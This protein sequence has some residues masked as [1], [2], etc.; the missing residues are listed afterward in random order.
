MPLN[1][2]GMQTGRKLLGVLWLLQID[3]LYGCDVVPFETVKSMVQMEGIRKY[4]LYGYPTPGYT[5][6]SFRFNFLTTCESLASDMNQTGGLYDYIWDNSKFSAH[7]GDCII[8]NITSNETT[9]TFTST[10]L[11]SKTTRS[12]TS[13][14]KT[15]LT[16]MTAGVDTTGSK[17]LTIGSTFSTKSQNIDASTNIV[18]TTLPKTVTYTTKQIDTSS[19][20]SSLLSTYSPSVTS[21][22]SGLLAASLES[23]KTHSNVPIIIALC[24][25]CSVMVIGVVLLCRRKKHGEIIFETHYEEPVCRNKPDDHGLRLVK[26][27]LYESNNILKTDYNEGPIY[28]TIDRNVIGMYDNIIQDENGIILNDAVENFTIVET[29]ES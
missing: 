13:L 2:F 3:S 11:L 8:C 10:T 12:K 18:Y 20:A 29:F 7:R 6:E 16:E 19:T 28:D 15:V 27:T 14:S 17:T 5:A 26:N 22:T 24:I 21:T 9:Q 25:I 1:F 23:K 4:N